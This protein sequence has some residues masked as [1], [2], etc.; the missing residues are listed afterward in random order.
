GSG[1]AAQYHV[2]VAFRGDSGASR[3]FVTD[4]T[5]RVRTLQETVRAD[6][7]VIYQQFIAVRP[8]IYHVD[9]TVRDRNGT[10][11]AHT[12]RADTVPRLA[13]QGVSEPLTVYQGRGG[14][15]RSPG[16]RVRG[17]PGSRRSPRSSRTPAPRS[18]T[19]PTRSAS[20]SR[21]TACR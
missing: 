7:S 17:A 19:A 18:P 1:F 14:A 11:V 15:A 13:G 3:E 2:D 12:Q 16:A 21:R 20:T 10:A 6:E 9:V 4:E 5:V 8:G